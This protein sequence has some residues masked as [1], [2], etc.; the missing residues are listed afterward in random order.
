M[1]KHWSLLTLDIIGFASTLE[2]P[3]LPRILAPV[4][5]THGE[6]ATILMPPF[7]IVFDEVFKAVPVTP[8]EFEDHIRKGKVTRLE[9]PFPGTVGY[10]LWVD[11]KGT[12]AYESKSKVKAAFTSLFDQH[13]EQAE[14][15]LMDGDY[16]SASAHAAIARAGNPTHIDPLVIRGAAE[17][18]AGQLSRFAFTRHLAADYLSPAAFDRLVEARMGDKGEIQSHRAACMSGMATRKPRL[19]AVK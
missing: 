15:A 5:R 13:L 14:K 1:S 8:E 19:C 3:T 10:D 2:E 4:F 12:V 17:Q 18:S 7:S 9:K 11:D 16:R 6:D